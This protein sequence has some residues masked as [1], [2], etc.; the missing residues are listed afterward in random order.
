MSLL[1]VLG[2]LIDADGY[3]DKVQRDVYRQMSDDER[4]LMAA[5][6]INSLLDEL[7]RTHPEVRV[8][9]VDE[10]TGQ[11]HSLDVNGYRDFVLDFLDEYGLDDLLESGLLPEPDKFISKTGLTPSPKHQSL[12]KPSTASTASTARRSSTEALDDRDD[13][14]HDDDDDED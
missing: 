11:V 10:D 1:D 9:I 8:T 5:Q 2:L 6:A 14:D 4:R 3:V 13:D 7:E 12:A